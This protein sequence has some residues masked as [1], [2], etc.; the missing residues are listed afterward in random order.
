MNSSLV[1]QGGGGLGGAT[2]GI[3]VDVMFH[4]RTKVEQTIYREIK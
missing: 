3:D 1:G 4:K 2:M